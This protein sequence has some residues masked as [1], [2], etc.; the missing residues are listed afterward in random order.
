MAQYTVEYLENIQFLWCIK[1]RVLRNLFYGYN[2]TYVIFDFWYSNQLI[3]FIKWRLST[4]LLWSF[5]L[6]Y[7]FLLG[8]STPHHTKGVILPMNSPQWGLLNWRC[9]DCRGRYWV[10]YHK[11]ASFFATKFPR[12]WDSWSLGIFKGY[13]RGSKRAL[14]LVCIGRKGSKRGEYEYLVWCGG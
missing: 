2:D 14:L 7:I 5:M 13:P 1:L 11:S 6:L 4:H 8:S 10:D 12:Y 9:W 3:Y